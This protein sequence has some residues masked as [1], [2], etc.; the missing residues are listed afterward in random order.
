MNDSDVRDE[1]DKEETVDDIYDAD[2]EEI[3]TTEV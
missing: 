1:L 2:G 3:L